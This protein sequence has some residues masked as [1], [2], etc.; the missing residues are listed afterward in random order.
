MPSYE[1]R[2]NGV[3][4]S[5]DASKIDMQFVLKSLAQSYWAD[6]RPEELVRRTWEHSLAFGVYNEATGVQVAMM[7]VVTDFGNYA[8]VF[9][10]WVDPKHRSKGYSKLLMSFLMSYPELKHVKRFQLTTSDAHKLYNRY[11]FDTLQSP[12]KFLEYFR[13]QDI[14]PPNLGI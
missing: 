4:V 10:V 14:P 3:V 5:T 11:G 8:H 1:F 9:D 2:S 12:E 6:T 13:N 7:R